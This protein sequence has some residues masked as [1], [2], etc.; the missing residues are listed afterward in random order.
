MTEHHEAVAKAV[1][2]LAATFSV[3]ADAMLIEAYSIG[4]RSLTPAEIEQATAVAMQQCKWMPK[5]VE[6]IEFARTGSSYEIQA[7]IA[8][9]ELDYALLRNEPSMMSPL[10]AA[11]ARQLGGFQLL[12][13]I[14]TETF[15]AF[16]RKDFLAAHVTLSKENP[17]RLA[18][19]TGPQSDIV[20]AMKLKLI[21]TREQ[22]RLREEANRQK[23]LK[24]IGQH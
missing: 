18:A 5:P 24:A 10:V 20:K 19:I 21:E 6:I 12:R 23:L 4:L 11:I 16:K 1:G 3:E 13:E 2:V 14:P 15:F 9:E 8:F 17:D 7:V 22:L